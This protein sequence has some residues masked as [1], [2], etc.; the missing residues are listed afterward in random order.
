LNPYVEKFVIVETDTTFSLLHHP[1]TFDKVYS[2]LPEDIKK[3]IVYH[4]LEVDKN[5]I[6]FKR[7]N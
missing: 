2:K 4:Y 7:R 5:F 1:K 6:T 3:K